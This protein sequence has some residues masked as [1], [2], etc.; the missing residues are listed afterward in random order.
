M[1]SAK[2][3]E[4]QYQTDQEVVI[5]LFYLAVP[6]LVD[7]RMQNVAARTNQTQSWNSQLGDVAR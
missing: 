7:S 5:E 6:P 2:E 3:T 4:R 1:R